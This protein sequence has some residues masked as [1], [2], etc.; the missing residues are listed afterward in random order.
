MK[1][2]KFLQA[3]KISKLRLSKILKTDLR[4]LIDKVLIIVSI[5]L[6]KNIL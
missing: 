5:K 2:L 6:I 3:L 4:T 1:L